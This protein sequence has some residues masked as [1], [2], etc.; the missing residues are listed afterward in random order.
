MSCVCVP[1]LHHCNFNWPSAHFTTTMS[2]QVVVD[3][4]HTL[5]SVPGNREFIVKDQGCLPGLVLFLENEDIEVVTKALETISLLSQAD[6]IKAHMKNE[7]GLMVSL[8]KMTTTSSPPRMRTLADTIISTLTDTNDNSNNNKHSSDSTYKAASSGS[9][10]SLKGSSFF[11][12]ASAPS[13]SRTLTLELEGLDS[14]DARKQCEDALLNIVG[15]ISFTFDMK[16]A[17]VSI[18]ARKDIEAEEYCRGI[19]QKY[20]NLKPQ[21]VVKNQNG[22]ETLID[23]LGIANGTT[24]VQEAPDYFDDDD[25]EELKVENPKTAL[26]P[27]GV[28]AGASSWLGST[29]GYI[30]KSLYW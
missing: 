27:T 19:N 28:G 11:S 20:S 25:E 30:K 8:E 14:V 4:L 3:Q 29:Y 10:F 1:H 2:A 15:T 12:T 6:S 16:L 18:R 7:L 21:Q 13:K 23:F 5:A 22:E 26:M 17:R 9:K 24:G